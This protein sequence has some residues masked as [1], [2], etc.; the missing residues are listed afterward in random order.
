MGC[1]KLVLAHKERLKNTLSAGGWHRLYGD[2]L[3]SGTGCMCGT[4]CMAATGCSIRLNSPSWS[5][6]LIRSV[7]EN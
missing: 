2:R 3:Y 4:G 1:W 7:A 5:E 6:V